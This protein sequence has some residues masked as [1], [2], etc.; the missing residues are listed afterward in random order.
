MLGFNLNNLLHWQIWW[1]SLGGNLLLMLCLFVQEGDK[2]TWVVVPEFSVQFH[3]QVKMDGAD[4]P[5]F[6]GRVDYKRIRPPPPPPRKEQSKTKSKKQ[7]KQNKT[8]NETLLRIQAPGS[9]FVCF[10][11][12][13]YHWM[14]WWDL[15]FSLCVGWTSS[16]AQVPKGSPENG[17][18]WDTWSL[19]G[20]AEEPCCIKVRKGHRSLNSVLLEW[21]KYII[22]MN[23]RQTGR[24]ISSTFVSRNLFLEMLQLLWPGF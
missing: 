2:K 21:Y 9:L 19:E 10:L 17:V 13:N 14:L 24:G 12:P 5:L 1:G 7:T 4:Y 11:K 15:Y 23:K 16:E 18:L 3:T 8:Q 22:Q 6:M 20:Y